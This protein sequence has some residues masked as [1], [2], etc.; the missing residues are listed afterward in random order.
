MMFALVVLRQILPVGA[1]LGLTAAL[2]YVVI[3][4]MVIAVYDGSREATT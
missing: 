3:V 1:D 4:S 2:A